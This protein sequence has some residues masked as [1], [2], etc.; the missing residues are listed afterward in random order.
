MIQVPVRAWPISADGV[1][2]IADK[3]Q[4]PNGGPALKAYK[5]PAGVWTLGLGE[6][7]G[8]KPGMT[9]TADQA[10][11]MLLRDLTTRAQALQAMLM[12]PAN[13]NQLGALVSLVYNIGLEAFRKSSVLRLH[14]KGDFAAAARAFDLWNKAK[15]NGVLVVMAG[16]TARRK[17]EAALYLTPDAE[18]WRHPMPQAVEPEQAPVASTRVQAGAATAG[19]GVL[20][21]IG[22]AKDTLGPVGEAVAGAKG[23]LADTLGVPQQYVPLALLV[24]VGAFLVWHFSKQRAQGV[25]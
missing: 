19:L 12:L 7:D 6:T 1:Q 24:A 14:N 22:E 4:G 3:E 15:V 2:L 10:W 13:E 8:I 11:D 16:L 21:A 9:C 25:A 23:L 20:G 17:A 18:D 5:C